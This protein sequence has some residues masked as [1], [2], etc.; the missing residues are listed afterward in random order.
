[1]IY[2]AILFVY[3][4]VSVLSEHSPHVTILYG[5][6]IAIQCALCL[7][8]FRRKPIPNYYRRTET[9]RLALEFSVLCFFIL[10]GVFAYPNQPSYTFPYPI[11]LMVIVF[12]YPVKAA[13]SL[14]F[15]YVLTFVALAL[16][17]KNPSTYVKDVYMA[18][19]TLLSSLTGYVIV[20]S[21]RHET[22]N[23]IGRLHYLSSTDALTG[24]CNK[25][26]FTALCRAYMLAR[27][28]KS[29]GYAM[30]FFD[31]DEFKR[32]NDTLGH[33]FGDKVLSSVARVI[34]QTFYE[35]DYLCRFGGDEF[36]VLMVDV[37]REEDVRLRLDEFAH[38][39][40]TVG[41]ELRMESLT[42]SVGYSLTAKQPETFEEL[43]A[44]ADADLYI[45]KRNSKKHLRV[46][47]EQ[48]EE[49]A[50]VPEQLPG[51]QR[52]VLIVDDNKLNRI[53]L[54]RI[55]RLQYD[56]L[57]A[58]N[59]RDA[60][61]V[62]RL[63][64]E[65][66]SAVLLDIVMPDIDGYEVLELM[67][68]DDELRRIPVVVTTGQVE[69]EA[70]IKALS[71][72]ADDFVTKPYR[73]EIIMHRLHNIIELYERTGGGVPNAQSKPQE[74]E[75]R[76]HR[77]AACADVMRNGHWRRARTFRRQRIAV[78]LLPRAVPQR[79]DHGG[80]G[81]RDRRLRL[82]RRLHRRAR[83]Q[84]AGGQH[85]LH[86]AVPLHRRAGGAHP[87]R[88]AQGNPRLQPRGGT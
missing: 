40:N 27:N 78:C 30:L 18:S 41:R 59:G 74:G 7:L 19:I 66:I 49:I 44:R 60:L 1:M 48:P 4:I 80:A 38:R 70:E 76:E 82:G 79:P 67:R 35:K 17:F 45:N 21:F 29:K 64:H 57:E 13:L 50:S 33:P 53:L 39:L 22:G 54:K 62:L 86:T 47:E 24:L 20:A 87:R 61:A 68:E 26:T 72:G 12:A 81:R 11:I 5:V 43:I 23:A 63:E 6:F 65:G 8:I 16:A 14:I 46:N 84:G 56:V 3:A 28:E 75:S 88:T 10:K 51:R 31:V 9:Y 58:E 73:A 77:P 71:L 83:P 55:L 37:E 85:G 15:G 25:Q 42:C 2:L 32:I 36:V 69:A 34:Q 52:R